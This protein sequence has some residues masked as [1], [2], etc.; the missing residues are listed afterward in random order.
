M[1]SGFGCSIPRLYEGEKLPK[2]KVSQLYN[3]NKVCVQSIDGITDARVNGYAME[4]LPGTHR[5]VVFF[6][7]I[8]YK[9][10]GQYGLFNSTAPHSS[11]F[12]TQAGHMYELSSEADTE[13][14]QWSFIINDMTKNSVVYKA[15]PSP[16]VF[17]AVQ[18]AGQ[19]GSLY[20]DIEYMHNLTNTY[21]PRQ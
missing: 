15:T 16:L 2:D 17:K 4:L 10:N 9:S 21:R 8:G 3:D 12:E 11:T 5:I 18:Q 6:A 19:G 14:L 13:K 20:G 7:G 1:L